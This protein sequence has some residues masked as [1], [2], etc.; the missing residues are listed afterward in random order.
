MIVNVEIDGQPKQIFIEHEMLERYNIWMDKEY[1]GMVSHNVNGWRVTPHEGSV[2]KGNTEV[3][4]SI[5]RV[6]LRER[7]SNVELTISR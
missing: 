4:D 2:L 1:Q 3:Y 5:L 6:F 7:D